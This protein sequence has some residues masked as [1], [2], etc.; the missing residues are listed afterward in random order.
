[1]TQTGTV[2]VSDHQFLLAGSGTDTTDVTAEGTL[3][4]TGPGFVTILTGIAY[5]PATL[6]V[7]THD[8]TAA[9]EEWETVEETVIDAPEDLRVLSVDGRVADGYALI[10]A[11]RY[12]VR[13]HARGR[14]IDFD[15]IATEPT[16]QYLLQI[17]PTTRPTDSITRLRKTDTAHEPP[18]KQLP[19]VDYEHFHAPGPDGTLTKFTIDSPEAQA[20][21]ALRNRW[22][23]RPPTGRLAEDLTI[24]TAASI[25]ADLD[26]DLV[27]E[28]DALSEDRLRALAR[29][30]ARRA[31]ERS[32]LVEFDDFRTA[33]DTMDH[34]TTPPPDFANHSLTTYRLQTDPA[35]P[36]TIEPGIAGA[37]DFVPQ[38]EA[39]RT[40]ML[41]VSNDITAIRA[42]LEAV[43]SGIATYGRDYPEFITRLRT[44]FL[45]HDFA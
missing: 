17:T 28:I 22:G 10:P 13:A 15:G 24:S 25:I 26:R 12:R 2:Q 14:D 19:Q 35:I 42:A 3:I 37:T 20:V 4:W 9:L 45:N 41:A 30:C 5:G 34:G 40:Y 38:Y 43:R 6:T 36:L 27:D 16:E 39:A 1:M 32:G 18:T 11:G 31:F 21:F 8:T 7:D 29:W 44:E 23:G 33:L